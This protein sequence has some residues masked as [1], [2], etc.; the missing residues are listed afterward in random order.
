MG[1]TP[2]GDTDPALTGAMAPQDMAIDRGLIGCARLS[3]RI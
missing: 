3:E 1:S 2:F